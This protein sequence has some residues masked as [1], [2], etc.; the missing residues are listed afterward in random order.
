GVMPV[1]K[2]GS[3]KGRVVALREAGVRPVVVERTNALGMR[4]ALVPPGRFLMGSLRREP[5]RS[6]NEDRHEVE[7]TKPFWLGVF[8]VTQKQYQ[9]VRGHNPSF[10]QK[11]AHGRDSVQGLD[12]SDFPVENV[13]WD[14]VQAF[15]K[16]LGE[17]DGA[18]YRLP[19]EAEWEHASRG[20][21][22][23]EEPFTLAAPSSILTSAHANVLGSEPYGKDAP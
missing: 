22:G 20:G 16:E 6:D 10:Y 2:R 19:S 21:V 4:F 18:R 15:L 7:I 1:K 3:V 9:A 23:F 14:D 12:T 11:T 17:K 5:R 8:P 13:D